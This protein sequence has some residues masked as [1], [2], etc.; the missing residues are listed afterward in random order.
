MYNWKYVNISVHSLWS[1]EI[2]KKPRNWLSRLPCWTISDWWIQWW[3][4][5]WWCKWL[6]CLSRVHATTVRVGRN[7]LPGKFIAKIL[8]ASPECDLAIISVENTDF[9]EFI[10]PLQFAFDLHNTK[11]G[12]AY[13]EWWLYF[14]N[15][16]TFR[17]YS[18]TWKR[19]GRNVTRISIRFYL[20][21]GHST[22]NRWYDIQRN[23]NC[24]CCQHFDTFTTL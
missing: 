1:R 6:H 5:T 11:D 13:N 15:E 24:L 2:H 8:A 10:S 3:A 22:R 20:T 12:D 19:Y 21:N 23:W 18:Y 14:C 4:K 17:W 7:G 9:W 16:N